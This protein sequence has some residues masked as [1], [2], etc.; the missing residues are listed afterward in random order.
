MR[1]RAS[2]FIDGN[3]LAEL[4][5]DFANRRCEACNRAFQRL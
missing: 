4:L 2:L 3:P 5:E 1:G